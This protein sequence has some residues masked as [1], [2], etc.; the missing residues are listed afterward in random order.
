MDPSGLGVPGPFF[1]SKTKKQPKLL[2]HAQKTKNTIFLF[3][4]FFV[5]IFLFLSISFLIFSINLQNFGNLWNHRTRGPWPE[6]ILQKEKTRHPHIHKPPRTLTPKPHTDTT[7]RDA[8]SLMLLRVGLFSPFFACWLLSLS[9]FGWGCCLSLFCW[10]V[11]LLWS[12]FSPSLG[13]FCFSSPL[14][15]G[16]ASVTWCCLASFLGWC[17]VFPSHVCVAPPSLPSSFGW[18]SFLLPLCDGWCCFV[19][20]FGPGGVAVFPFPLG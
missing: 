4:V 7:L 8:A 6:H 20:S 15:D 12:C 19:S 13:L 9:S 1:F 5:K 14:I 11:P 2:M 10:L 3:F 18:G 16:S 17:R